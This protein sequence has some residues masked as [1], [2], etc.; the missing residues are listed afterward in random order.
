M[1]ILIEACYSFYNF[2]TTVPYKE[3][4]KNALILAKS[5]GYDVYNC[6]NLME[7]AS[8]FDDLHFQMGDG[9]LNYYMYNWVM[10]CRKIKPEELGV[11]LF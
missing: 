5:F 9:N 1:F 7:N 8:V 6:L 3:L 2:A 10:K 4:I 11:V